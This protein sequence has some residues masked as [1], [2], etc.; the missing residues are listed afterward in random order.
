[1]SGFENGYA[2]VIG[3]ADYAQVRDLP[4]TVLADA[5][6]ISEILQDEKFCGYP[7]KQVELLLGKEA[8]ALNIK[9]KLTWLANQT[10]EED[11]AVIYFSG[12]GGQ[13]TTEGNTENYLIPY[14]ADAHNLPGTAISDTTLVTLLNKIKA[15]RL[16]V[17]FDACHSGGIGDVKGGTLSDQGTFKSGLDEGLYDRL[18][19]GQGRAVIASSRANEYSY[20]LKEM[21]N[22]IFTHY[23]LQAFKGEAPMRGDG[24]VRLFDLFDYVS[25]RVT[26]KQPKQHPILKAQIEKNFPIALHLGGQE[27]TPKH[28]LT[29]AYE[30]K[31]DINNI[32]NI[33]LS[34]T[35]KAILERMYDGYGRIVL[36]S[37]MG[38]GFGGGRVFLVHPVVDNS[39]ELPV[40]VKT[41]PI[42]IIEQEWTAYKQ[43]VE[44]KVPQAANI[45]GELMYAPDRRWGGIRYPLAGN[46]LYKTASLKSFCKEFDSEEIT[47]VIEDQLFHNMKEMWRKH[48]N[49]DV[50]FVGGSFDPILPVNLKLQLIPAEIPTPNKLIPETCFQSSFKAG[51]MV[52]VSGFEIVEVDHEASEI[53]LNYEN[54][55]NDLPTTYR[56]R[57]TGVTNM[58]GFGE[59]K[60]ISKP[61]IGIV[62]ETRGTQIKDLVNA[63]FNDNIDTT[64]TK[65]VLPEVGSVLNPLPAMS[66]YLKGH[67]H[68]RLGPIHGDLN[69]ENALVVYDRRNRQVFLIDFANARHDIVLHDFWRLEAGIWLYLVPDL[70]RKKNLSLADI[71]NFV[72]TIHDNNFKLPELEKPFEIISAIRQ[73]A[74]DYMV[75]RRAW[76]E[77]YNGLIVYLVGAMKFKNLNTE[78][79]AP[80]PKQ[81]AFVTAVSL[82]H[83]LQDTPLQSANTNDNQ[84]TTQRHSVSPSS[85]PFDD[86]NND[87][88]DDAPTNLPPG[89]RRDL[90]TILTSLFEEAE[91]ADICFALKINYEDIPG[92]RRSDKA[93]ELILH[94]ERHQRLEDLP[95][96]LAKMRPNAKW[97]DVL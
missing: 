25:E 75:K 66:R 15:G 55:N 93:R 54:T 37:E 9:S 87:S 91:L 29:K 51:D 61:L 68:V 32:E 33:Q 63:A 67:H 43:Y 7:E 84:T 3:I 39:A 53:T 36:K 57:F 50:A 59:G 17:L 71:P 30:N 52:A 5:N 23:L 22:S 21:P 60:I 8:T 20:V 40:I 62:Q 89:N 11:T 27:S 1:M 16:L 80:L 18:S 82:Y 10:G 70:L 13:L 76:D 97:G 14:E 81:V 31:P 78:P 92:N 2:L 79:S 12:H 49:L 24:L 19:Q 69:L 35:E 86:S 64:A 65:I 44:N 95:P 41:G 88:N 28:T 34:E 58:G 48:K 46:E 94:L 47:Y 74:T 72:Q 85:N 6:N 42:A 96:I 90:Y 83:I 77:Y 26:I 4:D 38:G 56:L 45:K 73:Q